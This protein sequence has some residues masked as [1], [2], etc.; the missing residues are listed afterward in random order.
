M[1]GTVLLLL[2][3][4]VALPSLVGYHIDPV[5]ASWSGWTHLHGPG[6]T[7]AQTVTC[8]FD[9]LSYVELFAGAKGNG[10]AYRAGVWLDGSEVMGGKRDTSPISSLKRVKPIDP[11]LLVFAA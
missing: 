4:G 9:S 1:K 7:V 8:N 5:K 6:D 3:A 10:G 2:I 11:A